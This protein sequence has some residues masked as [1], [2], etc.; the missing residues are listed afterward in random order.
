MKTLSSILQ[1]Q[2]AYFRINFFNT[3]SGLRSVWMAGTQ[4][5][6]GIKNLGLFNSIVHV[7]SNPPLIGI[8]FRPQTVPRH[9]LENIYSC[10]YFT[11]NSIT[12]EMIDLAHRTSEKFPAHEDEFVVLG[13]TPFYFDERPDVPAVAESPVKILLRFREN[14]L[15][16]SNQT[17]FIVSEIMNVILS[18]E[19]GINPDGG[20]NH[21][22][23]NHSVISGLNDY[24]SIAFLKSKFHKKRSE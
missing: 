14:H 23:Y 9:T 17:I 8:V 13:F 15:I 24:Y 3:L 19:Q 16:T 10:G 21:A 22:F 6:E 18:D 12:Q 1:D 20:I 5:N 2:D 7:G 11:L 4:N